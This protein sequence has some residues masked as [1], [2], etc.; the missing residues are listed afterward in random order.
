MITITDSSYDTARNEAEAT[1]Q[2]FLPVQ[3]TYTIE[4]VRRQIHK[5]SLRGFNEGATWAQ[6]NPDDAPVN[7]AVGQ[8]ILSC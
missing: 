7:S 5:A 6:A 1:S 8:R 4:E 2:S 3:E